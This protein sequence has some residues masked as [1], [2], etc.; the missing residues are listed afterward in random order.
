[1]AFQGQ[2]ISLVALLSTLIFCFGVGVGSAGAASSRD[3]AIKALDKLL[4][5][6]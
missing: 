5:V 4:F 1:L 6:A 3:L 2:N